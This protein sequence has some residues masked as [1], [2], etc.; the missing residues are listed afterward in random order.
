[1]FW[2][3]VT[4]GCAVW[5]S[6]AVRTDRTTSTGKRCEV[7]DKGVELLSQAASS[8][9]SASS[10]RVP[11]LGVG[12]MTW[13]HARGL[14]RLH[15]AK[16][17]YG[18]AHVDDFPQDLAAR[19]TT[20]QRSSIDLCQHH[21]P[22]RRVSIPQPDGAAGR[23]GRRGGNGERNGVSNCSAEQLRQAHAALAERGIP[24][25]SKQVEYSLLRRRPETPGVLDACR[26][27]GVTLIAYTP[28][29]GGLLTASAP[30]RTGRAAS[31]GA[32]VERCD[33][34]AAEHT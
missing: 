2:P 34:D 13:G 22:T 32:Q 15:P 5:W 1:M 17:A 23:C 21:F 14:A 6:D 10:L 26:K 25:A 4:S 29:A 20:L 9:H 28:L 8:R 31:S 19:L 7:S 24:L 33:V 11:R 3:A 27:L 30:A 18:G 12:A 16:L